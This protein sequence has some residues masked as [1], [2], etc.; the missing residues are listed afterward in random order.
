MVIC[1]GLLQKTTKTIVE[2]KIAKDVQQ[3]RSH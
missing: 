1:Q 2:R 3:E